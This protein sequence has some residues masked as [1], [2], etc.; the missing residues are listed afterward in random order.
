MQDKDNFLIDFETLNTTP[1]CVVRCLSV[2]PFKLG[3]Q[4]SFE[5]IKSRVLTVWFD[6]QD[7]LARLRTL[8][9]E[10][11]EFW[12]TQLAKSSGETYEN[13]E[14]I[15]GTCEE[16]VNPKE[17]LEIISAYIKDV[18]PSGLIYS[19]GANFDFPIFES[20]CRM[21]GVALPFSTWKATCSKSILRF[22]CQD[23]KEAEAA[24]VGGLKSNHISSTDVTIEVMKLQALYA[25]LSA[26]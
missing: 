13:A 20:L 14:R 10:T 1:D 26:D 19:R 21:Y 2:V 4:E 5:A 25:V 15:L 3:T 6:P 17:A 9:D 18:A 7:Q 16:D 22:M 12:N 11:I 24:L 8:D 23:D